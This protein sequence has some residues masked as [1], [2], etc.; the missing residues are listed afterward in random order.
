[1]L[2]NDYQAKTLF[3]NVSI[4]GKTS[5]AGR[6]AYRG[7]L[8]VEEGDIADAQGRR[9]PPKKVARQAVILAS[10]D[11]QLMLSGALDNVLILPQLL[12]RYAADF[13]PDIKLMF[14]VANIGKILD[15]KLNSGSC[16]LIPFHDGAVWNM[17]MEELKLEKEDFKGQSSE[18]K[19]ITVYNTLAKFSVQSTPVKLEELENYIVE[20]AKTI[21]GAV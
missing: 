2:L 11:K 13:A 10:E 6:Y 8:V 18:D 3:C 1:M 7:D 14:F 5:Q 15:V 17:L 16:Y 21:R 9:H 19:V 4:Q 12:E 20:V